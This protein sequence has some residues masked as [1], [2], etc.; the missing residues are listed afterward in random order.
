MGDKASE[1]MQL[2]DLLTDPAVLSEL[3]E[4]LARQRLARNLTQPQLAETAG[5]GRATLQRLEH[6][7][8]VQLTS[9]I[10]VLR[11][12]DLLPALDAAIPEAVVSPLAELAR[13][14][15]PAR[16]RA[17]G[18]EDEDDED[19]HAG[20]WRWDGDEPPS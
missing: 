5:I 20:P 11:A 19:F 14:A 4:R 3:G 2:N 1:L 8:S 10:R 13:A 15:Q 9:L 7:E 17:R 16:R 6:G 18:D 12:L